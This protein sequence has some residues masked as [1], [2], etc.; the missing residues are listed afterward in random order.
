VAVAVLRPKGMGLEEQDLVTIGVRCGFV[1]GWL[2]NLR[3]DSASGTVS[4]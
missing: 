1:L 4:T 2:D 3:V